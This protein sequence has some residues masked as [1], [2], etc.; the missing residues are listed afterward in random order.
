MSEATIAGSE[1]G[2]RKKGMSV[3]RMTEKCKPYEDE[4]DERMFYELTGQ[5]VNL[6]TFKDDSSETDDGSAEGRVSMSYSERM[7][8]S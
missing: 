4:V 5:K 1:P 8:R 3:N 6:D 2:R 7:S